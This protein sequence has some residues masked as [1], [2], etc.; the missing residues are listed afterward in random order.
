MNPIVLT[1]TMLM[2]KWNES[3]VFSHESNSI[4][5]KNANVETKLN[6]LRS[7]R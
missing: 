6:L 4:D 7:A 2:L 5:K 1:R 3:N